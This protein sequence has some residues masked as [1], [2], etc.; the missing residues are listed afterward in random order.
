MNSILEISDMR[1][2]FAKAGSKD[3]LLSECEQLDLYAG[4]LVCLMGANGSGKSTLIS[5][6]SG[7]PILSGSIKLLGKEID[8]YS[9]SELAKICAFVYTDKIDVDYLKVSDLVELG[10]FPYQRWKSAVLDEDKMIIEQAIEAMELKPFLNRNL[11]TLSDGEKQRAMIARAM[12]QD[13]QILLLDEPTSFLDLPHKVKTLKLLRNWSRTKNRAVLLSTHDLS[14]SMSVADHIWLMMPNK[15][16][17]SGAPE[18]LMLSNAIKESFCTDDVRIN[19]IDGHFEI[20]QEE[21]LKIKINGIN[22]NW[23]NRALSRIGY[24]L[25]SD[26]EESEINLKITNSNIRYELT[27]KNLKTTYSSLFDLMSFLRYLPKN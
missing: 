22:C 4:N 21:C 11:I 23:T 2:G 12:A 1:L 24:G 10:R 6:L 20:V 8:S 15:K 5:A 16:I 14:L 26:H 7:T 3:I 9:N 17:V 25:C 19:P 13:P 18:G 27:V